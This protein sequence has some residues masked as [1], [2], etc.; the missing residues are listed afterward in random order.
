[1]RHV[2][3]L[4]AHVQ[5]AQDKGRIEARGAHDRSD[6]NALG[7]YHRK[8]HVM[9]VEAGVLHVD[10]GR[11][12]TGEPDQFHDL[13]VGDAADMGPQS[14]AAFARMRFTRFSFM[15]SFLPPWPT[16]LGRLC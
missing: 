11:I 3:A 5:E 1:M 7:R 15:S 10:E 14:E 9:Q 16:E 12:E 2:D 6:S 13:R 4:C 8:L